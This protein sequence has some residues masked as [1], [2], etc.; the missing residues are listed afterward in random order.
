MKT[1]KLI[2]NKI[3]NALYSLPRI[4]FINFYRFFLRIKI[5]NPKKIPRDHSVIFAFNHTTGA[6]PIIALG[7]LRRK[8]HFLADS[9]RFTNRF[10]AFFMRKFANSTPVFQSEARKNIKS[11]KELFLISNNKKVFFGIFPEGDLFKKGK[12]GEFR[13]GAAYLSF[14]TKIPI[15]PVYMHNVSLGPTD[16]GWVGR[17]PVFEGIVSLF[18]NTYRKI[19][20]FVGD[21]IDPM[22]ENIMEELS[23]LTD[24]KEY[25]K[26]IDKITKELEKEFLELKEEAEIFSLSNK[27]Q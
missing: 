4:L 19:H 3:A 27:P 1:L 2:G 8:I 16:E 25:K 14:K 13:D 23:D 18:M 11:F 9:G 15:V 5:S 20:V 26:I 22:A 6:D 21:P 17:H 24:K 7:A 10:T 12:F